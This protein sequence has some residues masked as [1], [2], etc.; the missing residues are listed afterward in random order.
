MQKAEEHANEALDSLKKM[1]SLIDD[2][3][4]EAP[5][6]MK[7]AARRNIK[8]IL[9]DVDDAKKK[10]DLEVQ[11][12]NIAER[13]WKQVKTARENLN[14]ELQILFPDINIHEKKL[15]IDEDS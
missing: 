8:R 15:A 7:T 9:D 11:S 14:E 2:P 5:S 12:G 1:F 6:H 3:K 13:Y 10:Y 4:F